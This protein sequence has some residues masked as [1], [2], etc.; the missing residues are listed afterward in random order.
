MGF[1]VKQNAFSKGWE[2]YDIMQQNRLVAT[3]REDGTSAVFC[4]NFMPYNLY[5]DDTEDDIDTRLNNL[6]NFYYWC[7]SR[8]LTLDRKYA[9]EIMNAIGVSQAVTDRDRAM[10]AISCHAVCLTD[11]FWVRASREQVSY[12]D[13]NLYHH[14]LS[15]AFSDVSL[16]GSSLT[17]QDEQLLTNADAAGDVATSGVAPKA[18]IRENG[19]LFLLKDGDVRDVEAEILASKIADCFEFPHVSYEASLF[20][21]KRVSRTELITSEDR[22]IVSIEYVDVYCANQDLDREQF[23]LGQDAYAFY[24]MNIFDYVV[25]N[26]DRHWGN[27]GFWVDNETNRLRKLHPLMDFNKAFQ[28]YQTMEGGLCQTTKVRMT[29]Q[30]AAA[31]AAQAVGLNQIQ[32]IRKEWFDE[33]SGGQAE[34]MALYEMCRKRVEYLKGLV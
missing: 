12:E 31:Q 10:I 6:N 22:S 8:V 14:S 29:Q 17:L 26:T 19:A 1:I 7:A 13:I 18:W 2:Q 4:R 3:I 23:A 33:W 27:W 34:G 25:G 5:L 32:E 20:K 30:S 21:G 24:M 28:T 9:K 15:D 11:V 16:F